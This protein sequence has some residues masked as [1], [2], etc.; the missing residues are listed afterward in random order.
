M[1]KL[2][3]LITTDKY[4][5]LMIFDI[6]FWMQISFKNRFYRNFDIYIIYSPCG[7]NFMNMLTKR[8]RI[9]ISLQ[10]TKE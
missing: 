4:Y 6:K 8:E 7:K 5:Q 2:G 9:Y 3:I 10:I 1:I